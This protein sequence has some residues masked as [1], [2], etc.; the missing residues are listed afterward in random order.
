M[1][2]ERQKVIEALEPF[3]ER[4][5]RAS[6]GFEVVVLDWQACGVLWSYLKPAVDMLKGSTDEDAEN[7][8][9]AC[10]TSASHHL[11][12]ASEHA[13]TLRSVAESL[14]LAQMNMDWRLKAINSSQ[15]NPD[16]ITP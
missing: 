11:K 1:T 2:T 7:W 16:N 9:Q 5:D 14:K 6:R 3:A 8:K 10:L 4:L 15:P 13:E 12:Q